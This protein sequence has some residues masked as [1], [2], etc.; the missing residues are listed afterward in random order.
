MPSF[1]YH[2]YPHSTI[3]VVHKL[4]LTATI[5]SE[6]CLSLFVLPWYGGGSFF[7][8]LLLHSLRA[9]SLLVISFWEHEFAPYLLYS[10]GFTST[11]L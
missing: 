7:T 11:A 5:W 2:I 10:L 8:S 3:T 1:P 4:I 6:S 9:F